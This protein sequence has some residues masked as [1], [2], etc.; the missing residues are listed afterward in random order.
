[1]GLECPAPAARAASPVAGRCLDP[2]PSPQ[3]H[4]GILACALAL[5]VVRVVARECGDGAVGDLDHLVRHAVNETAVVGDHHQGSWE[6][7]EGRLERLAGGN[8]EVVGGLVEQEK[9][10]GRR[11]YGERQ[12]VSSPPRSTLTGLN[13][14][15]PEKRKQPRMPRT[16]SSV[17]AAPAGRAS[18]RCCFPR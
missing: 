1:M 3:R 8:V 5:E 15:S 18:S 14:S 12:A 4:L 16:C 17:C 2:R 6:F 10:A 13:T 11:A 7:G 9:I